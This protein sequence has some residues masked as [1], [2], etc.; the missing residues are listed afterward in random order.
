MSRAGRRYTYVS[1]GLAVGLLAGC[2]GA[3]FVAGDGPADAAPA[4]E[5][6][7][8]R[9]AEVLDA[10]AAGDVLEVLDGRAAEVLDA[11]AAGDVLEVLDGRAAG[12]AGDVE[13]EAADPPDARPRSPEAAA[14]ATVCLSVTPGYGCPAGYPYVRRGGATGLQ[15]CDGP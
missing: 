4:G 1:L 8:G 9:A 14:P 13:L 11:G 12:D 2:E 3:A 5:L 6:L 15:C 10:G 7:D